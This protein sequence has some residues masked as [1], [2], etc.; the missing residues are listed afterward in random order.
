M[1][2]QNFNSQEE[3]LEAEQRLH[4]SLRKLEEAEVELGAYKSS[5]SSDESSHKCDDGQ[6]SFVKQQRALHFIEKVPDLNPSIMP[7]P[8][9]LE[10][11]SILDTECLEFEPTSDPECL[12]FEPLSSTLA[13]ESHPCKV[14][15]TLYSQPDSSNPIHVVEHKL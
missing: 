4:K 14:D 11:E 6:L 8:E 10:F 3:L 9:Y 12:E 7:V 15:D 13:F 2:E 1:V 5:L